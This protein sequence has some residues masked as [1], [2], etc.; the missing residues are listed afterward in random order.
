MQLLDGM[1]T[2]RGKDGRQYIEMV[3]AYI[4]LLILSPFQI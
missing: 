4:Q 2:Q 1:R 3:M